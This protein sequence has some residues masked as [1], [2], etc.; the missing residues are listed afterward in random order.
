MKELSFELENKEIDINE[1]QKAMQ[2]QDQDMMT[3]REKVQ[4]EI[5]AMEQKMLG[6]IV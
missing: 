6:M 1:K 5:E 3:K 4:A 2:L